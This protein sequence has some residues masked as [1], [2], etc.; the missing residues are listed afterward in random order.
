MLNDPNT[1]K[2]QQ[3]DDEVTVS[4]WTVERY[5]HIVKWPSLVAIVLNIIIITARWNAAFTWLSLLILTVFLG[6]AAENIYRGTIGNAA[7][8]GFAAGLI[9]GV[10]TSL[11]QF[12]W[13]HNVESF[14]QI[15][16]TSLLSILVSLLM[17]ASA[18][19]ILA[20]EKRPSEIVR[21]RRGMKRS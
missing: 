9:V 7:G 20:R 17:S 19:L 16:T 15:I 10:A 5:S 2:E 8:L 12:L 21:K 13:Y 18:F 6:F 4:G 3:S 1:K 14:F 11:Y